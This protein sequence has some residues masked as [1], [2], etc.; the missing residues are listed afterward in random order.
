MAI[1]VDANAKPKYPPLAEDVYQAVVAEVCDW[2]I[3]QEKFDEQ[4]LHKVQIVFQLSA[5]RDDGKRHEVRSWKERL[6]LHEK[7]NLRTKY[8]DK[9]IG[10]AKFEQMI[11]ENPVFDVESL[12]GMNCQIEVIHNATGEYANIGAVL[13]YRGTELMTVT[14]DY[15]PLQ[16]RAPRDNSSADDNH[17]N[18]AAARNLA[19]TPAAP[20]T[21]N[22]P[23]APRAKTAAETMPI[24]A[25]QRDSII[26]Q[27]QIS[28]GPDSYKRPLNTLIMDK[29][30]DKELNEL[31]ADE[32]AQLNGIL[33]SMP[34][35]VKALEIDD[36]SDEDYSPFADEGQP[37]YRPPATDGDQAVMMEVGA[38]EA[39]GSYGT[40]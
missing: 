16:Q 3:I 24:K 14:D 27:A 6:S 39:V 2:G 9:I 37:G 15:T 10:K 19:S 34:A 31:T 13:A 20:V 7:A 32:A 21:P 8:I 30:N 22:A 28:Y 25:S 38:R 5:L 35:H 4:P 26:K 33:R 1:E 17:P 11:A 40:I 36:I 18:V 23:V 29:F 12:V